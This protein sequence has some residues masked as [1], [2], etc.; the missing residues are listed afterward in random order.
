[1]SFSHCVQGVEKGYSSGFNLREHIRSVHDKK[2]LICKTCGRAYKSHKAWS[3]HQRS[4]Q[5]H[6]PFQDQ[7]IAVMD[8]GN[9]Y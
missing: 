1:M 9:P 8:A 7:R 2:P 3:A 4:C 5:A 6:A